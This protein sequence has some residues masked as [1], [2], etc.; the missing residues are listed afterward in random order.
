[1]KKLMLL[2]LLC[3]A[4]TTVPNRENTDTRLSKMEAKI[5]KLEKE[6]KTLNDDYLERLADEILGRK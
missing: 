1:M 2:C 4:C 5:S 6:M 3:G